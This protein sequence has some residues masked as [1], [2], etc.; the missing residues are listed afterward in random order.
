MVYLQESYRMYQTIFHVQYAQT[1]MLSCCKQQKLPRVWSALGIIVAMCAGNQTKI[2]G[3]GSP[4][5]GS[6]TKCFKH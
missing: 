2:I 3:S 6:S 5:M 4:G 1:M